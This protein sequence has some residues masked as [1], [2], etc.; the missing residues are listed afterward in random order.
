METKRPQLNLVEM[1]QLRWLLGG[2]LTL[3]S[4]WTIF[5]LDVGAWTLMVLTTF[6][7][8]AMLLRPMLPARVPRAVHLLAFPAM[9]AFFIGD[10]WLKGEMLPALVRL[11]ILLLLYRTIS[12]RQ[13]RDDLQIIVLGLFLI[14]VAGVLTVS[15]LFAVQIVA[16]TGC[17]LAFLLNIT[18][19]EAG[20]S[21]EGSPAATAANPPIW[22]QQVDWKRLGRRLRE[23]SDWRVVV[24]GGVIFAGV[25]A[26]SALLFLAIP[27]FQLENSLFIERFISKKAH[28]GFNDTIKFGDVTEIQQDNGIALSVDVSDPAQVPAVPYWRMLVLD[29]YRA[30]GFRF[31]PALSRTALDLAERTAA[32]LPG[33]VRGRAGIPV[34]WTFYLEP[35]VSRFLPLPGRFGVLRF[36]EAQ[37][38][39]ASTELG[40]VA[41]GVE[42]ASMTA[43]RLE[44]VVVSDAL[45]DP[46][47]AA[48]WR[49][50]DQATT[51]NPLV[52]ERSNL[53]TSDRD[54]MTRVV[55]ELAAQPAA[56]GAAAGD[57]ASL[58][59]RRA[60]VWLRA[61]HAYSLSPQIPSGTG[62]PLVRWLASRE[63]GHCELFAGSFVLLA[64]TAGFASRVVVGFKG[65]TWNGYSGNFTVR[66]ANAHAW[67]EIW[68]ERRAAWLRADPL[69]DEP[70]S[71]AD[72]AQGAATLAGRTDRSGRARFDSLRVFWY[73]R[74]VN[75]DARSQGETLAAVKTV[76]QA[77]GRRAREIL[78]AAVAAMKAWIVRPW[79]M[80]RVAELAA[81][82]A[83]A[84]GTGWLVRRLKGAIFDLRL[85]SRGRR[86]DPVR[87]EA[88][89]LLA[90]LPVKFSGE[91]AGV[92]DVAV[93]QARAELER[94][95]FGARESWVEPAAVLRRAKQVARARRGRG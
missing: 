67:A 86:E 37:N 53:V 61:N 59:A 5:Y 31:S 22:A 56:A 13:R 10:L 81:L 85:R 70:A 95:R 15:L 55:G 18:I 11:D 91:G 35:G 46:I 60:N 45:T 23:V 28:T 73:R 17:A 44:D 79:D 26:V 21:P 88:A 33:T 25:V 38:F 39:R 90:R 41:L 9:S 68:D 30:G 16:F 29:E 51:G 8:V 50:R 32:V 47:F 6:A 19:A 52:Q 42:P 24:L 74:I 54:V 48:R 82:I 14:V 1:Q 89:R 72:A 7:V 87:R 49:D 75:F 69:A 4:V 93:D 92:S 77:T 20:K 84:V 34:Y 27:R 62:D 78:E 58:F 40:V 57:D 94:L 64:R 12:Y 66:N 65:G 83:A 43:Y 71:A 80:R 36:R 76:T 3:L 2:V 63:P